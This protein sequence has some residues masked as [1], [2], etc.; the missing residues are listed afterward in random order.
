MATTTKA[1]IADAV[2]ASSGCGQSQAAQLVEALIE[3]IKANL[4]QGESVLISG[5]GKFEVREKEAR[6]G[7]NP[8]TG[9]RMKLDGRRVVVFRCS[10]K[11]KERLNVR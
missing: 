11:L 3:R 9:E 6:L 8:A 2:A 4:T 5:F 7:R 1:R 10:Q